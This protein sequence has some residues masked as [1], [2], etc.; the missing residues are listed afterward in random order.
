MRWLAYV[1]PVWMLTGI[2]LAVLALRSGLALRRSRRLGVGR[3]PEMRPRHLR[4]AK[5]AVVV[6]I[7]GFV[8]GPISAVW[9]RGME[10][11]GTF[12][13][14]LG[15]L[16]AS[17]FSAAAVMGHRIEKHHSRAFDAHALLGTLAVLAAAVGA[18]AGFVLLP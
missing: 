14:W 18:V 3:T 16:A 8:G 2:A 13:A 10:P 1:H 7:V 5:P 12:H 11:F 15:I 17:L 6:L 4:W 9:L